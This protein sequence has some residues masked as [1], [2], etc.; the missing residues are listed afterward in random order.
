MEKHDHIK[1]TLG[2]VE[3]TLSAEIDRY[4]RVKKFDNMEGLQYRHVCNLIGVYK[5]L[6]YD[7]PFSED[8]QSKVD[9]FK[10]EGRK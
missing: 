7:K 2:W 10:K 8:I 1:F 6:N 4:F 9:K 3:E 5:I